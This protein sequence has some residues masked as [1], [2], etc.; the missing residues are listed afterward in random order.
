[1]CFILISDDGK[2]HQN[3]VFLLIFLSLLDFQLKQSAVL[4]IVFLWLN[5]WFLISKYLLVS[6]NWSLIADEQVGCA[7]ENVRFWVFVT[8][9]NSS[10]VTS[11]QTEMGP[12]Q[13]PW[14]RQ[15]TLP[16]NTA[17]VPSLGLWILA[18]PF[19]AVAQSVPLNIF[20][21]LALSLETPQL[22][23]LQLSDHD[24]KNPQAHFRSQNP[25]KTLFLTVED[26]HILTASLWGT[27]SGNIFEECYSLS[28]R[29]FDFHRSILRWDTKVDLGFEVSPKSES[30]SISLH[31][32]DSKLGA[33]S[34][35]R[36]MSWAMWY[37]ASPLEGIQEFDN[38]FSAHAPSEA[39][40]DSSRWTR[41]YPG[42]CSGHC[43][44][45]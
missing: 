45:S 21:H 28:P 38:Q 23:L 29:V 17:H 19:R 35:T 1:M 39:Q 31:F 4:A 25:I 43:S 32:L 12:I 33:C 7:K 2:T 27:I 44:P 13:P 37:P 34:E 41:I 18:I 22:H 30:S 8:N 36:D 9:R 42:H 20:S 10:L 5:F 3:L 6:I 11:L 26:S 40:W 14:G 15:G 24:L 16:M